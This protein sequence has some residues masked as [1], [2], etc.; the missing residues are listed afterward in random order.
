MVD[1]ARL[2]Q[3]IVKAMATQL[4]FLPTIIR[5]D[6]WSST[7]MKGRVPRVKSKNDAGGY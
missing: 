7:Y 2:G 4:C 3:D 5:E 6:F 1:I